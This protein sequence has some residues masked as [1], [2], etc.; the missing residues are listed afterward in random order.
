MPDI[1]VPLLLENLFKDNKVLLQNNAIV[2][3]TV[4]T[5]VKTVEI[6]PLGLMYKISYIECM[7]VMMKFGNNRLYKTN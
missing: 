6:I 1:G 5:L 2:K 7:K 4:E 3:K